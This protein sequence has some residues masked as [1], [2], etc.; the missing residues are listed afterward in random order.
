[1]RKVKVR[2]ERLPGIGERFDLDTAAGLTVTII[3]H[4]AGRQHIAISAPESEVPLATAA[5]TSPEARALAMLLA[6]AHVEVTT[7]PKT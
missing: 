3:G 4:R 5:L 6:G 7:A 1:M 2:H